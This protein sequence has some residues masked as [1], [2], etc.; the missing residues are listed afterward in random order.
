MN[1][2]VKSLANVWANR[3]QVEDRLGVTYVFTP[4]ALQVFAEKIAEKCARIADIAEEGEDVGSSIVKNFWT[5]DG[6]YLPLKPKCHVC[7]TTENVRYMGGYQEYLCDSDD[8][9]PF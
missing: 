8:C 2:E 5:E 4:A 6:P 1:E 9:I 3:R 7:G